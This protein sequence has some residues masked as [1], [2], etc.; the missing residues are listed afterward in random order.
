MT[1]N[2]ERVIQD[3]TNLVKIPSTVNNKSAQSDCLN[4]VVDQLSANLY[5]ERYSHNNQ[6]SVVLSFR[7]TLEPDILLHGHVDVV[8][9][10]EDQFQPR[11]SGDRLSGRGS[12]DMK[13][14][15]ACLMEVMRQFEDSSD[16][17]SLALVLVTDEEAGGYDG[18]EYLLDDIG[19]K[20][21]FAISAE[22]NNTSY[23]LPIVTDQKGIIGLRVRAHGDSCHAAEPWEGENAANKLFELQSKVLSLF[24]EPDPDSWDTTGV[25][26]ELDTSG[27][28]NVVPGTASLLLN[29]R[30]T[31]NYLPEDIERDLEQ[32]NISFQFEYVEPR[33]H[34][35]ASDEGVQ[36][37]QDAVRSTV[38]KAGGKLIR[39]APASDMRFLS[40]KRIP[41][42][43]F[44]P[45]GHNAHSSDE[46]AVISSFETYIQSVK[47]FVQQYC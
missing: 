3:T 22:P 36:M 27:Y 10:D 46:Y 16:P 47:R 24:N 41:A 2:I 12:G 11:Q 20:P 1:I 38:G 21:S 5:V 39:K 18:V 44:G 26:T 19:Y 28:A 31:E 32:Q 42:V 6:D 35:P 45:E 37:L 7:D 29:I 23:T 9:A 34:T 17:P 13:A 33:L 4:Y 15:V 8:E 25:V 40:E 30:Y 43:V 14:G